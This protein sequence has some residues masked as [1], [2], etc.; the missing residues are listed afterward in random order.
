M[1]LYKHS[2]ESMST[3]VTIQLA[4][5]VLLQKKWIEITQTIE[6]IFQQVVSKYSRFDSNSELSKL[7]QYFERGNEA[8]YKVSQ[9]FFSL[10]AKMLELS[11]FSEGLFDPTIIDLLEMYGYVQTYKLSK[12]KS[13]GLPAQQLKQYLR[14]RPSWKA[15]KLDQ[16]NLTI[17]LA[18]SQRLDL[19]GIGKGY[20]LDLAK[21][22]LV[23]YSPDFLIEAGGDLYGQG[24]D[25]S[26]D[27]P[28]EISLKL[29]SEKGELQYIPYHLP[30]AGQTVAASGSWA[31]KTGKFHHLLNPRT[32]TPE[33]KV[34]QSFVFGV[35]PT[36]VDGLATV[37]FLQGKKYLNKIEQEY[38][39]SGLV[40][41]AQGK[42]W[43]SDSWSNGFY[44]TNPKFS[45]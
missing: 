37:L 36:L 41:D 11:K 14:D 38:G 34:I 44:F 5:S 31:R 39:C 22:E 45:E 6:T 23:K 30:I 32:G 40:Y 27:Q 35:N 17:S 9:E 2:F 16:K 3:L 12:I 43:T 4:S 42:I 26:T 1:Q 7:N 25:P 13:A 21:Q 19:G 10:I 20:A 29:R 18:K 24:I 8:P 15:I 33:E 28:W